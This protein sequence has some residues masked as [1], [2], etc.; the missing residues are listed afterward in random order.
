MARITLDIFS[1][2]PNPVWELDDAQVQQVLRDIEGQRD[3]VTDPSAGTGRLGFRGLVVETGSAQ[4]ELPAA[5]RLSA[6]SA[7]GVELAQRLLARLGSPHGTADA[8]PGLSRLEDLDLIRLIGEDAQ[9]RSFSQGSQGG[10]FAAQIQALNPAPVLGTDASS[11][12][13]IAQGSCS[14]EVAAF[15]PTF[16][17]NAAYQSLNNCYN[18]ASNRRTDT[19]AQPGK[20][21][22]AQATRMRCANVAAGAVADG[23]VQAPTCVPAGNEPRWYMALVI[24]PNIDYHWYRKQAE[25]YWGHKPGQTAA[26]N[27]DNSNVVITNPET[28]DRGGYRDFCGYFFSQASHGIR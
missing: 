23:A 15:N 16:W 20:A 18:Y 4:R 19:F 21:A 26:R 7:R 2:R 11:W 28:A 22:G 14:I 9:S 27:V 1:G 5:F 3:L 24:W 8:P 13:T 17:N 10:G 25:G 6:E 12:S